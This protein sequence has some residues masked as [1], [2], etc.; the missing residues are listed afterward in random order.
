[1]DKL[2][3]KG[4]KLLAQRDRIVEDLRK[5]DDQLRQFCRT[6]EQAKGLRGL[7]PTHL[8]TMIDYQS[9]KANP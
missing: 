6:Y 1:M 4:A 3:T 5:K 8:R 9:K 7:A 2:L